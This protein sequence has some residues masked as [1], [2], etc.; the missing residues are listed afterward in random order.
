MNMSDFT[1]GLPTTIWF[2]PPPTSSRWKAAGASGCT[3]TPT[4][5]PPRCMALLN[6]CHYVVDFLVVQD[7]LKASS[8]D[9]IIECCCPRN[10]RRSVYRRSPARSK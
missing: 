2:S 6:D 4:A 3:G 8:P 5:W 1:F 7:A 10:T 9:W